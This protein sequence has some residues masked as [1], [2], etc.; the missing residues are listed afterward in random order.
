MINKRWLWIVLALLT[1]TL[2]SAGCSSTPAQTVK[3][4]A[5]AKQVLDENQTVI[6]TAD[7]TGGYSVE[8]ASG[9]AYFYKG[10]AGEENE[11]IAFAYVIS[12]EEY[13]SEIAYLTGEQT[14]DS[15]F[16]DLGNG[17]YSNGGASGCDYFF[18]TE[19]GLY[20]KVAVEEAGMKEAESIYPR[21][22]AHKDQ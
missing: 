6:M 3:E 21:F 22:S 2:L 7:L 17:L 5:S 18:P 10:E 8:F 12:K 1:L 16:K 15:E 14:S 19:D 11:P 13:D 9:A 20:M 4:T